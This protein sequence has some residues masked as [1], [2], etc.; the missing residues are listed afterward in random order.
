MYSVTTWPAAKQQVLCDWWHLKIWLRNMGGV[1]CN[2]CHHTLTYSTIPSRHHSG[3][4]K[5]KLTELGPTSPRVDEYRRVQHSKGARRLHL[6]YPAS[7]LSWTKKRRNLQVW[8][9]STHPNFVSMTR[10][11]VLQYS[12]ISSAMCSSTSLKTSD[13]G[14]SRLFTGI[15]IINEFV[16]E[17]L[18]F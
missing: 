6:Y 12:R 3:V 11:C 9:C 4:T 17:V 16:T 5:P 10:T 13:L 1:T 2:R 15:V 18:I 7:V 8:I 14:V